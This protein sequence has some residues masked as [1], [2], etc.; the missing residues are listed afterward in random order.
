MS[1]TSDTLPQLESVLS[2]LQVEPDAD[3]GKELL[4]IHTHWHALSGVA[5]APA[6]MLGLLDMFYSRVFDLIGRVQVS[7]GES[8]LPLPRGLRLPARGLVESC[9]ELA[10]AYLDLTRGSSVDLVVTDLPG[11]GF[12]G[13]RALDLLGDA[14]V[15]GAMGGMAPRYD[16]WRTAHALFLA[17]GGAES[18][19]RRLAAGWDH[20]AVHAYK[21]LLALSVIQP[22]AC[23]AREIEWVADFLD[24]QA[25]EIRLEPLEPGVSGGYWIDPAQDM[26]PV[27]VAR[28][29]PPPVDGLLH[30]V[31]TPLGR[32]VTARLESLTC[33]PE[34]VLADAA[35]AVVTLTVEA[36][37]PEGLSVR[38]LVP[39]LRRLRQHWAM[40]L[41]REQPRRS[42]RY[43]VEVC[44]GLQSIWEM[45]R[46]GEGATRIA[47]WEVVNEGPGGL[48]LRCVE[49]VD[50]AL[51]AGMAVALRRKRS[52]NWSL[53]VVRWIRTENQP[54]VEVGLQ[55]VAKVA[56]P[57][58]LGFSNGI[59]PEMVLG[60]LLPPMGDVRRHQAILAPA[61]VTY[62]SPR[63]V[64]VQE[65][66]RLHVA[67]GR[68]LS[69]EVQTPSV[70]LFQFETDPSPM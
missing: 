31:T 47:E 48:A 23:S 35:E 38:E 33:K 64:F 17:L 40:P 63:F 19:L 29:L 34:E 5:M 53:G 8:G 2:W 61:G 62:S 25:G 45:S 26:A 44:L 39:L 21:R 15:V 58:R 69:M 55:I 67:Q 7:L 30:L 59:V 46:Q 43:T 37:L 9:V 57:V 32:T 16:L 3:P 14:W 28:R 60:L 1:A 41:M 22:E 50:F 6:G 24:E 18:E 4:A 20:R 11:N 56:T 42:N 68:L 13:A 49:A 27:A 65:D 10:G 52:L 66:D 70:E 36:D 54:Q 51:S 12:L